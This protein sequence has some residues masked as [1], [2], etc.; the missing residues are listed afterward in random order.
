M[1]A[2]FTAERFGAREKIHAALDRGEGEN[3]RLCLS[4]PVWL[5]FKREVPRGE[6]RQ[7]RGTRFV[8]AYRGRPISIHDEWSWGWML[9]PIGEEAAR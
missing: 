4:E 6:Y 8:N 5:E 9:V 7:R 3:C 2:A 1:S